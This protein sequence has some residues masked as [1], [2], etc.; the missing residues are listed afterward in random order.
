MASVQHKTLFK[1][2]NDIFSGSYDMHGIDNVF[3]A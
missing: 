2:S 1:F 3:S